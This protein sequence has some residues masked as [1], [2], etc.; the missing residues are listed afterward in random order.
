MLKSIFIFILISV[1]SLGAANKP[2]VV[3]VISDDQGY[4]D[5]SCHGNPI[6]KTPHIDK[7]HGE[8][9]RLTDYHVSPTCA[10]TRGALMSGHYTN[11]CG[12]WHT[13]M[14]RSMLFEGEKTLGEVFKD[15]GYATGMF[16]K[17]H[18]GDNYPYRPEDRGFTEVVR[19]GG[20]GAG[21]TPDL[22][23]N[24]YFGGMY[25]HNGEPK[26]YKGYC[27]DVFF[28]EAKRFIGESISAKK[29]FFAYIS[30]NAPHSPFHCEEKYWK[31]YSAALKKKG[32]D[33]V[34]IFFGMIANIDENVGE[35]RQFLT[36]KGVADNT[37][38]IFTTDNGSAS[39]D[40]VF[41]SGMSGKK[42]SA[43]EGG[44]RVPFFLHWKDGGFTTG[45]DLTQLS[46][47][48]DVLP[49]LVELCGIK[50]IE[51]SYKLDGKSLVPLMKNPQANWPDRTIITDSQRVRD[52]IKW[53]SCSTMT[54]KWRLIDGKKLYDITKDPAQSKDLSK[55]FPEVVSKLR[56]DYEAWW[57]DISPA[58]KKYSRIIVG[59]SAENPCTLTSHDWLTTGTPTPWNQ[60]HIRRGIPS[61]GTWAVKVDSP[62]KYKI[63]IRRWPREIDASSD[64]AIPAGEPVPGLTAFRETPGKAISIKTAGI[65]FSGT[66]KEVPYKT[67][68][69]EVTFEVELQAGPLELEGYFIQPNGKKIGSY[70]AYVE[71]L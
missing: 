44:H 11:R 24:A 10:P 7:L 4:G 26:P 56:A 64:A 50:P 21:Q 8:S 54:Q 13:I 62:G 45:T 67:G 33:K 39:G 40:K 46:A 65:I 34:A 63:S 66:K 61:S 49:T 58:F 28:D 31:P 22:W 25:F 48:I 6:L 60:N 51:E 2:N 19:H 42:G 32:G 29:P 20:G 15:S 47:H 52:P 18:L 70:Y 23:D 68:S 55:E 3:L 35:I 16:G 69:Q 43:K 41:N 5:L 37:I 12:P 27:S 17:W 14:G 53:K 30:T 38:F 9:I 71:K 59:N 57:T 1:V 36:D